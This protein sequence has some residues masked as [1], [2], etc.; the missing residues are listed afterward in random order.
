MLTANKAVAEGLKEMLHP[1]QSTAHLDKRKHSSTTNAVA[2][3]TQ[4][5]VMNNNNDVESAKSG[6]PIDCDKDWIE[7]AYQHDDCKQSANDKQSTDEIPALFPLK[8]PA[9]NRLKSLQRQLTLNVKEQSNDALQVFH[10]SFGIGDTTQATVSD[11]MDV[12]MMDWEPCNDTS[13]YSF[14]QLEDMVVESLTDSAYI[15]P[16]TNVFLDSLASI[17]S[18]MDKGL[19]QTKFLFFR[20]TSIFNLSYEIV[21]EGRQFVFDRM[22]SLLNF[23]SFLII[24]CN[25]YNFLHKL[26]CNNLFLSAPFFTQI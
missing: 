3:K 15:V 23:L 1:K 18:I 6:E 25:S 8:N 21:D 20:L 7:S 2:K 14:Q 9:Q 10:N 24:F 5:L 26:N 22:V 16:D 4:T 11:D 12:D 17:K 19:L 13:P